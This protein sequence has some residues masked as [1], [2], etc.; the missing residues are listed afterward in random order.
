MSE[1]RQLQISTTELAKL[2]P[3][4]RNYRSHPPEQI[5]HIAASVSQN[6][7]YRPIVATR[8]GYILAG[9]GLALA[10]EALSIESVPVVILDLDH[11]DPRALKVIA[12]D[13]ELVQFADVDDRVLTELLKEIRDSGENGLLGT[14]YSDAALATLI[15]TTRPKSEIETIDK[16]EHWVGMPEH[17]PSGKSHIVVWFRT[18]EDCADFAKLLGQALPSELKTVHWKS[19]DRLDSIAMSVEPKVVIQET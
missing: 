16:A 5:R 6:G 4:P 8:D 18:E 17:L 11:D 10:A 7:F 19:R 12:S 9:H 3:H 14:G 1:Y 15:F 13:N 2:R